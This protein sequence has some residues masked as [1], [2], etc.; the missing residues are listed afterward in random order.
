MGSPLHGEAINVTLICA[1][2]ENCLFLP[3][4]CRLVHQGLPQNQCKAKLVDA[5]NLT[6]KQKNFTKLLCV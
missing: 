1:L 5:D 3:F 4:P 2:I 6:N